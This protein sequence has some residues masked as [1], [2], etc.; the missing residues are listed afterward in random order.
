MMNIR[1]ANSAFTLIYCG[2]YF[3]KK[4][5]NSKFVDYHHYNHS[6]SKNSLQF[7]QNN[8]CSLKFLIFQT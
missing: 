4:Y 7:N 5:F 6:L 8:F 1:I 3:K 2:K